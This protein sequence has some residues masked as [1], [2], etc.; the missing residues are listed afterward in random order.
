[1]GNSIKGYSPGKKNSSSLLSQEDVLQILH[2][3]DLPLIRD[4]MNIVGSYIDQWSL[5]YSYF[6]T[7]PFSHELIDQKKLKEYRSKIVQEENRD[8][9][10][11]FIARKTSLISSTNSNNKNEMNN[12]RMLI[13]ERKINAHH[14]KIYDCRISNIPTRIVSIG[15]DGICNIW[16]ILTGEC[17]NRTSCL[18]SWLMTCDSYWINNDTS[19]LL[20]GG[21]DNIVTIYPTNLPTSINKEK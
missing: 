7:F 8:R 3:I 20:S 4:L 9:K 13:K 21:L 5:P 10:Q 15:G 12:K 16:D 19:L 17:I 2:S 11:S 14:A 6:L 1:M 18:T